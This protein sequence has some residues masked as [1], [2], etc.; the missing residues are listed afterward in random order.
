[1]ML[2]RTVYLYVPGC[3]HSFP[4]DVALADRDVPHIL[5]FFHG[6][7]QL[8]PRSAGDLLRDLA[9]QFAHPIDAEFIDMQLGMCGSWYEYEI[10]WKTLG[11]ESERHLDADL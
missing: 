4:N 11:I 1:M 9:A 10:G 3:R 6:F 8:A 5:F 2:R 7:V